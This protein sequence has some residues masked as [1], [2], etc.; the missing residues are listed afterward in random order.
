MSSQPQI[1]SKSADVSTATFACLA[2]IV[3]AAHD[4]CADFGMPSRR[5]CA[6]GA[7]SQLERL[8][9]LGSNL[10]SGACMLRS[11]ACM[12][13]FARMYSF[14][15][16][17]S[18]PCGR[19]ESSHAMFID[20]LSCLT[21][22]KLPSHCAAAGSSWALAVGCA[23]VLLPQLL[24]GVDAFTT[25]MLTGN[26]DLDVS[27]KRQRRTHEVHT[28]ACVARGVLQAGGE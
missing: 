22:V 24:H 6:L 13:T 11:C 15:N 7:D 10:D 1:L 3:V 5:L 23:C 26:D 27:S 17:S 8:S 14:A 12:C 9:L 18:K 2:H 16:A 25:I 28:A 4:A 21:S 19:H 20:R